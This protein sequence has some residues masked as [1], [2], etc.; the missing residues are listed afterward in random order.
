MDLK[1]ESLS[2]KKMWLC[3]DDAVVCLG[4]GITC[5]D[6][7]AEVVTTVNQCL[8]EGDVV[9]SSDHKSV[10]H[11]GINYLFDV[12]SNV[13]VESG[14]QS[15]RWSDIGAG[16]NAMV[17]K[18][19]MLLY[20]DHGRASKDAKYQYTIGF[21]QQAPEIQ[22]L[23]NTPRLQ[24]VRAGEVLGIAFWD[25]GRIDAGGDAGEVEADQPC[26]VL[27]RRGADQKQHATIS[28]PRQQT[29]RVNVRIS[30][31]RHTVDLKDGSSVLID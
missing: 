3:L 16:S 21:G 27:I 14:A 26:V 29:M 24:A 11:A 23:A 2:A 8:R 19:V 9:Q 6:P 7:Q 22:T 12:A 20:I 1:R 17:S 31:Q 30:G 13:K 18:D 10:R 15:G 5:T 28:N 4:A 25:A